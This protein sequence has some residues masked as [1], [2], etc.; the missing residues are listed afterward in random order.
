ACLFSVILLTDTS[1]TMTYTLSLHDALPISFVD[2]LALD[3][4]RIESMAAGC[5]VVRA[6][7][8]PV[9]AVMEAWTR[10]NGMTIERVRV[11]LGVVRSEEHT[12]ELQSRG[13]LVCRLL[14]EK[15]NKLNI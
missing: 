6:L 8:D 3:R 10:P 11:P 13:H 14:L 15:K 2:R 5:E 1:P 12:S 7:P 4:K 9:G